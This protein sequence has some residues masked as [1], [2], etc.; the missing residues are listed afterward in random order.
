MIRVFCFLLAAFSVFAQNSSITQS[1]WPGETTL[2]F[3]DGSNNQQYFCTALSRQ[4]NFQWTGTSMITSI[5][6]SGTTATITFVSAHGLAVDNRILIRGMVSA[7]TSALNGLFNV[8]SVGSTTT[9]TV[10][11]SGVTDGTYTPSTDPLMQINTTAPRTS[12]AV[13]QIMRQYFTTTY[14]DRIAL[15]EGDLQPSKI[16]DDRSTYSYQ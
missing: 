4:P 5:A 3:R 2:I 10:T 16:C 6:D 13:W 7:G 9:L 1:L 8:V 15:A 11:T 14:V 12:A